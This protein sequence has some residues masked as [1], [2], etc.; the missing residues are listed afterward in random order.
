MRVSDPNKTKGVTL[1]HRIEDLLIEASPYLGITRDQCSTL[2]DTI[3]NAR[4]YYTHYDKKR[5]KPTFECISASN[6]LLHFILLLV[7]YSLL[8]I[9]ENAINECKKYTPYK[10]M[11]YYIGEIK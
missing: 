5:T 1:K 10:N 3:S 9:P 6:E 2:A 7:V 11:T 8:G 4:N